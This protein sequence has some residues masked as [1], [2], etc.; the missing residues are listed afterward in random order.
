MIGSDISINPDP[1]LWLK[2]RKE[3]IYVTDEEWNGRAVKQ[4]QHFK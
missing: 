2:F 4:E 1:Q 3:R